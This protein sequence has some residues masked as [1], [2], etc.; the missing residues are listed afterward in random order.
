MSKT[1][2]LCRCAHA[3]RIDAQQHATLKTA[4][5][6]AGWSVETV[7]D[8]CGL[9]VES[10]DALA[11]LA[12]QADTLVA[13]HDRALRWLLDRAG[14]GA[15]ALPRFLNLMAGTAAN[16]A[17]ELGVSVEGIDAQA[18][19]QPE[20]PAWQPWYPVVDYDR[21]IGCM[22]CASFCLFGVYSKD[23]NNRLKVVYPQGCKNL[24]PAC[25]RICPEAAIIFPKLDESPYNGEPIGDETELKKR[26]Q[27][28]VDQVLGSDIYAALAE[29]RKKAKQRLLREDA[30][31]QAEAERARCAAKTDGENE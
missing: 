14:V 22:Q 18:E 4:L 27:N 20:A 5:V 26:I 6:N 28:Q 15:E 10:P 3:G 23:E 31:K 2:L 21:C 17:Q 30:L 8:L 24:C 12:T 29:R 19:P 25:A 13:C 1:I 11:Q 16:L 9:A 7:D